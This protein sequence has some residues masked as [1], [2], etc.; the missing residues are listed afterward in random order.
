VKP[1]F[2][3]NIKNEVNPSNESAATSFRNH[4]GG[5]LGIGCVK[6]KAIKT[7]DAFAD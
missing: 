4:T 2:W 7:D 5:I 1:V 6:M 3:I